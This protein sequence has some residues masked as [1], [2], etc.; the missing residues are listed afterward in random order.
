MKVANGGVLIPLATTVQSLLIVTNGGVVNSTNGSFEVVG[1]TSNGM[2]ASRMDSLG[3]GAF[4]VANG[5]VLNEYKLSWF[6]GSGR[7]LR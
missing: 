7:V 2:L 4:T 6:G 5:G 3:G 1:V